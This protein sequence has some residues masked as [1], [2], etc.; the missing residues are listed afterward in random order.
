MNS[1][2][3]I[4]PSGLLGRLRKIIPNGWLESLSSDPHRLKRIEETIE[5]SVVVLIVFAWL[6]AM[7]LLP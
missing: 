5:S 3:R 2:P 7:T 1:V 4:N 6:A